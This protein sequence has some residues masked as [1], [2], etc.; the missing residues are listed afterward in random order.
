MPRPRIAVPTYRHHKA[1]GKA[2]SDY[3]DPMT[4][5]K[6]SV[7]LGPWN[8][9]ESRREHARLC[10]EVAAGR[11][12][13]T[14]TASLTVNEILL[15]YLRFA[16]GY[17]RKDGRDTGEIPAI[18]A[19]IRFVRQL[20]GHVQ[21]ESFGPV[22]LEA[23]RQSMIVSGGL[24]RSTVNSQVGR[25]R[26]IFRW[27]V[28][29]Q[30]ISPHVITALASLEPL[31][32][33]RCAA[34]ETTPIR[35]V[36]DSVVE[37]VLPHLPPLV[38]DIVRVQRLTGSRPSEVCG[39][40]GDEIDHAGEVWAYRP[41]THKTAHHGRERAIF[42]GPKAQAI[43]KPYIDGS[44]GGYLF[45]PERSEARRNAIKNAVRT[46][47]RWASHA[48]AARETRRRKRGIKRR[49]F[50]EHYSTDS[51]RRAIT[52]ACVTA[53][54]SSF[55]PNQIRHTTATEIRK[56]FGL[57]AAQVVLGHSEAETTQIYAERDHELAARVAGEVG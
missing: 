19:A 8:S 41:S 9:A 29:R 30:L 13:T 20:Y 5:T 36:A 38:A 50:S 14:T 37:T 44:E 39:M 11:T 47:P 46:T 49:T 28:A 18:K 56:R 31:K 45:R 1:S 51:Y 32:K 3:H 16:K 10:A 43:L 7:T 52:R 57:E 12:T 26:R 53:G 2:V 4:G 42:I 24:A 25:I 54:V 17:Y 27:A 55:A 35:P 40:R 23:V 33:G 15:A 22:A 34:R 48:P 6:R 21:A